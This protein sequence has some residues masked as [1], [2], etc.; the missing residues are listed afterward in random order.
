LALHEANR[1]RARK[2]F[3]RIVDEDRDDFIM[4]L[5]ES[6]TQE[7]K[8]VVSFSSGVAGRP[9]IGHDPVDDL[10]RPKLC[11]LEGK[12]TEDPGKVVISREL[13]T[14]NEDGAAPLIGTPFKRVRVR[15]PEK[16]LWVR[17][18]P[19]SPPQGY[20]EEDADAEL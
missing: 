17:K 6:A 12:D 16:S 19:R 14:C 4:R 10:G 2:T 9:F 1:V 7:S 20:I 13:E 5:P 15:H 18:L 3:I 8:Y 11:I